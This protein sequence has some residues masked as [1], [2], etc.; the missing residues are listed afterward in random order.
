MLKKPP[1]F[2][3]RTTKCIVPTKIFIIILFVLYFFYARS[4]YTLFVFYSEIVSKAH[5]KLIVGLTS[6]LI[7]VIKNVIKRLWFVPKMSLIAYRYAIVSVDVIN[8]EKSLPPSGVLANDHPILLSLMK[9]VL[10][11]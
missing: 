4:I 2:V 7:I 1:L 10:Y 5:R 8:A 3:Q 11:C 9:T 6:Y